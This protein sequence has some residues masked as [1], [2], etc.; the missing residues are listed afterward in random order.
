VVGALGERDDHALE[1]EGVADAAADGEEHLLDRAAPGQ[2]RRDAQQVLDRRAVAV[3]L[4]GLLGVLDGE[5]G[6][7][8]HGAQDLELRIRGPAAVDRLV[9]RDD[10]EQAAGRGPQGH[11]EG[12]L[13]MPVLRGARP[14]GRRGDVGDEVPGVPLELVVRDEERAA[15]LEARVE[16]LLPARPAARRAEQDAARSFAAVDDRDLEVV[17]RGAVEVDDDGPESERHGDR[18]RDRLQQRLEVAAGAHGA[19]GLQ[20]AAQPRESAGVSRG[21]QVVGG[22]ADHRP[23]YRLR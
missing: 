14:H 13:G 4:G 20:Q 17:P 12:V 23:G 19:G 10:A 18:P 22:R 6:M 3:G 2:P 21:R 9:D 15:A 7:A 11:E 8:A 5:R 1:A 16:E